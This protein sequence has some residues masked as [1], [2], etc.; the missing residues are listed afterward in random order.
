MTGVPTV[1]LWKLAEFLRRAMVDYELESNP[2]PPEEDPRVLP[3]TRRERRRLRV[4]MVHRS[5]AWKL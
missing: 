3:L 4:Q 1:P 2:L 5:G